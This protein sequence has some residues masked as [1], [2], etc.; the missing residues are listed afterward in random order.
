MLCDSGSG[1]CLCLPGVN[2][3]SCTQCLVGSKHPPHSTISLV[4]MAGM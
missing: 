4:A 3:L 2:G 1:Q